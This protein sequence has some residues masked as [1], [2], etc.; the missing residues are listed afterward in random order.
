MQLS[1]SVG[2]GRGEWGAALAGLRLRED[3]LLQDADK[4]L[5]LGAIAGVLVRHGG[6]VLRVRRHVGRCEVR[7]S[8]YRS[9]ES[10]ITAVGVC[11]RRDRGRGLQWQRVLCSCVAVGC[12]DRGRGGSE[13][14]VQG[15]KSTDSS[16][17]W[18]K[19]K[20][21]RVWPDD[22]Y[23]EMGLVRGSPVSGVAE[24]WDDDGRDAGGAS[25]A[26]WGVGVGGR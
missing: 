25:R 5:E 3:L 26:F 6:R 21:P 4:G 23:R 19:P 17:G 8:L 9:R 24:T 15:D 18:E 10:P 16:K 13:D 7:V 2:A 11:G 22:E 1:P 12:W 20:I 14:R